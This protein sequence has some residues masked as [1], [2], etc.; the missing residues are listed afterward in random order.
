MEGILVRGLD[1]S[2]PQAYS[3]IRL[4][5]KDGDVLLYE[6]YTLPSRVIRWA[7]R[8]RYTHAGVAVWWNDRLM[9]LEAVGRG[10]SVTPLSA[11]LRHYHGHVQW[12]TTQKPLSQAKRCEMIQ[13]AQ[14]ELGKG[15]ALWKSI[16]LGFFILFRHGVDKRDRLRRENKLYCSWYVAQIF[17]AVGLD[18]KKGVSD[19]FITPEDIARSPLLV[20]RGVLKLHRDK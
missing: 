15:Y 18:L 16:V 5:I 14:Q 9:V 19:R 4:Q 20:R 3:D 11:N 2:N 12:F 6:G 17:N 10:V 13:F 1:S 8:S 7:T